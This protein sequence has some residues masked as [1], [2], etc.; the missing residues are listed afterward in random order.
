[1]EL[2]AFK[3]ALRST[4]FPHQM[5]EKRRGGINSSKILIHQK[6]VNSP[7]LENMVKRSVLTVKFKHIWPEKKLKKKKFHP[8]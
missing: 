3:N 2:R 5:W 4:F 6:K 8:K 7:V 1:M